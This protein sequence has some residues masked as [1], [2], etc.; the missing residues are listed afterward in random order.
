MRVGYLYPSAPVFPR[1]SILL[2]KG[3]TGAALL[4]RQS[5]LLSIL[6]P[7]I[8]GE[9]AGTF[10]LGPRVNEFYERERGYRIYD[11]QNKR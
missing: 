1:S 6:Q 3:K 10:F 9:G 2:S 11:E 5:R 7:P 4:Q 8:C